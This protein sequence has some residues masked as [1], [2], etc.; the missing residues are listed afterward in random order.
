MTPAAFWALVDA[1]DTDGC[2]PWLGPVNGDRGRLYWNG[3][4]QYA[5]RVAWELAAGKPVPPDLHACHKC[6]NPICVRPDHIFLGTDGDNIRDAAAKGR[7]HG[8]GFRGEAHPRSKG[9]DADVERARQ[10]YA[11]G[12]LQREIAE[13]LGVHQTTVSLWVRGR[14]RTPA[15]SP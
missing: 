4:P 1:S 8:P 13:A 5:Y 15:M 11:Q 2:W 12:C 3:R 7:L 9:S 6:D 14:R 10:M